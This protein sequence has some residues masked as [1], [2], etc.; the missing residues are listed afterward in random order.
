MRT[1][2]SYFRKDDLHVCSRWIIYNMWIIECHGDVVCPKRK[3][4]NYVI[5][6]IQSRGILKRG[7]QFFSPFEF[8][9][10]KLFSFATSVRNR[11]RSASLYQ[12]VR[13]PLSVTLP[14]LYL[15]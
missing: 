12:I 3:G 7:T 9:Q 11:I 13:L 2:M 15:S 1:G 10:S 5:P 8:Y 4:M 14:Q 6:K